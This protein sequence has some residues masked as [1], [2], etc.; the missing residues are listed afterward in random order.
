[1]RRLFIFLML[2]SLC[3]A[4]E[5]AFAADA[6]EVVPKFAVARS[7][8]SVRINWTD[9]TITAL[10]YGEAGFDAGRRHLPFHLAGKARQ[11]AYRL[12]LKAAKS[13]QLTPTRTVS[14]YLGNNDQLLARFENLLK[15]AELVQTEFLSTGPVEVTLKH[16]LTGA[17]SSLLLP[18]LVTRLSGIEP[19]H[20]PQNAKD[21][22]YTG[23]VVDARGLSVK[24]AL[25]FQLF[26]EGGREVYGPAYASRE[27]A[28]ASGMCRYDPDIEAASA[29]PRVGKKPLILRAVRLKTP[30][31]SNIVISNADA[32][33]LQSSVEHLAFLRQCRV[34]VVMDDP[35]GK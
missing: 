24:P 15:N 27:S 13:V 32:A 5:P 25:C 22:G 10:G 11:Q 1:M 19:S 17:F 2:G 30:G 9:H 18:D 3:A 14:D 23:L 4:P 21:S 6:I 7:Q 31:L 8:G 34:I 20:V 26:S 29:N 35:A 33:R 12:L 28:V 16:P